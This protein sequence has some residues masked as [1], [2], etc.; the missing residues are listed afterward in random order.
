M[1]DDDL[2]KDQQ[3]GDQAREAPAPEETLVTLES[4][5]AERDNL[6]ARLQ[7]VSADYVNYQKRMER[8]RAEA[9]GFIVADVVSPLFDVMDDLELAISHAREN[10]PADDPLLVGTEMVY[11]KALAVFERFNVTPIET[12]GQTFDPSVHEAVVSQPTADAPPM[13][14]LA[15]V[16]KGYRMGD[17]VIRPSRVVVAAAPAVE[18][19]APGEQPGEEE[20]NDHADV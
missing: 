20:G 16:R 18:D 9:R 14:I 3:Q 6:L 2:H 8:Q 10:H 15:E 12:T 13:T 5:A 7:R 4:L 1:N 11:R 17:R 19:N